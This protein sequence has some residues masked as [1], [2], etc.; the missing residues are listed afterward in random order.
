MSLDLDAESAIF[1]SPK[2]LK[3]CSKSRRLSRPYPKRRSGSNPLPIC[4]TGLARWYRQYATNDTK[5][6]W[7]EGVIQKNLVAIYGVGR[8]LM[9]IRDKGYY[10][11]V[12][13][14]ETFEEYCRK[15]WD[16]ARRTAY[17]YID[18][19]RVRGQLHAAEAKEDFYCIMTLVML[20]EVYYARRVKGSS[21][22]VGMQ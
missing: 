18:G 4:R 2:V 21:F 15:R 8:A 16:I 13:G 9:E 1:T 17:Q 14:F 5:L 10:R 12:L 6:E 11:E 19:Q 7:L 22:I 20:T 3:P